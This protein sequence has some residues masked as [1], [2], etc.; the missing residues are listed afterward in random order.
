MG[1]QRKLIIFASGFL[2]NLLVKITIFLLAYL[3]NNRERKLTFAGGL[4][5]AT[6]HETLRVI[7]KGATPPK[8]HQPQ[9]PLSSPL[10]LSS[11]SSPLCFS[12]RPL[13]GAI[14]I[15]SLHDEAPVIEVRR[16]IGQRRG[17][18]QRRIWRPRA[19]CGGTQ[20]LQ[21]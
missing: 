8:S 3:L 19:L 11:Y 1:R 10:R 21:I 4:A 6:T 7:L 9:H 14:V 5:A 20:D 17:P 18:G 13:T 16:C 12:L 2:K 15:A